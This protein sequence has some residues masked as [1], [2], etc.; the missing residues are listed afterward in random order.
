LRRAG[1]DRPGVFSS[2][3]TKASLRNKEV[4]RILTEL[5]VSHHDL[6]LPYL[7]RIEG[8]EFN[9]A[10]A[11]VLEND[12]DL[13]S[14]TETE[15]LALF[16]YWSERGDAEQLS[17]A[18]EQHRDWLQY[19]WF[20]LAKYYASK[21]DFKAAYELTERYGEP[22]ALPRISRSSNPDLLQLESWF[23]QSPD[24]YAIGF[25]LYHAQKQ[26]GRID[27][28]LQTVRHFSERANTPAYWKY[29]EAQLWAEK[30]NYER[31]WKASLAFHAA[32]K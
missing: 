30:Q 1:Q 28:A 4:S 24:N 20:G 8:G 27:D 12:P 6:A 13:K 10:L 15:K 26:A 19:A 18:V 21:N 32:T 11:K 16:S 3:L 14:F 5:G 23:R 22:V 7:A 31:A 25:E 2:M 17:R 29:L 9:R